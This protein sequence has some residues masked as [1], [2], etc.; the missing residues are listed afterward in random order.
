METIN[1]INSL[2]LSHEEQISSVIQNNM[3]ITAQVRLSDKGVRITLH[4]KPDAFRILDKFRS[5]FRI[6][7]HTCK[8]QCDLFAVPL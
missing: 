7:L 3:G 2:F 6:V 8:T 1:A 5:S 4:S